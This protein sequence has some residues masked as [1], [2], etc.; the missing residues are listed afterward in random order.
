MS[1]RFNPF[2][3]ELDYYESV[4]SAKNA[5]TTKTDTYS[6]T[7]SDLGKGRIFLMNAAGDKIFNLPSVA[8]GDV[9]S[10][11]T[12]GKVG[13]GKL[14]IQAADSDTIHDSSAGGTIYNNIAGETYILIRLKLIQT[15][16]W[17]ICGMS[18]TGWITT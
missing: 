15:T 4:E 13:A 17:A 5:V 8:A 7:I 14:T 11:I 16:K 10:E 9:G 18:G 12:L 3:S 6:I 1:W 2:T